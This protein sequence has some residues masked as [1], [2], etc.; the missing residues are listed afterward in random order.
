M[1][2]AWGPKWPD[3]AEWQN[4]DYR[5]KV[6]EAPLHQGLTGQMKFLFIEFEISECRAGGGTRI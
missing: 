1:G 4:L 5:T 6:H 3:A 2:W